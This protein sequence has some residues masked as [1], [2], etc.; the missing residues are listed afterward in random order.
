ML[1]N[2]AGQNRARNF[3]DEEEIAGAVELLAER[4]LIVP[5][6]SIPTR[7]FRVPIYESFYNDDYHERAASLLTD[8]ED[9]P[10]YMQPDGGLSGMLGSGTYVRFDEEFGFVYTQTDKIKA[11]AYT[12]I[13]ADTFEKFAVFGTALSSGKLKQHTEAAAAFLC[14]ASD[15]ETALTLHVE[16]SYHDP[17]SGL[18]YLLV[19]QMIGEYLVHSHYAV[20]VFREEELFGAHGRWY[21]SSL[22]ESY[23]TELQN[24]LNILFTDF[25]TLQSERIDAFSLPSNATLPDS[26]PLPINTPVT[27][28]AIPQVESMETRY[29]IYWNAD[30]TALYFIPAWHITHIGA[31]TIVYNAANGT[32]Y[33]RY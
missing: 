20:L 1:Y 6:T 28:N 5:I 8:T 7:R 33:T 31:D 22:D 32:I 21:F 19:R 12:D 14:P 17:K 9:V 25:E 11:S 2:I 3:L 30:K 16:D 27:G 24:Q 13:T 4:G 10:L 23:T 26:P 29:I 15:E 18:D